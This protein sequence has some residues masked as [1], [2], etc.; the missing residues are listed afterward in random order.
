MTNK[1]I[2]PIIASAVI[3]NG[4]IFKIGGIVAGNKEPYAIFE[5]PVG[6]NRNMLKAYGGRVI[7]VKITPL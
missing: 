7:K 4:E 1:K 5:D 3:G 6:F 2:K